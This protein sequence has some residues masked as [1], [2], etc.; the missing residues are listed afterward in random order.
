[1]AATAAAGVPALPTA[2]TRAHTSLRVC[3]VHFSDFRVDSR[4]QRQARA[5]AERGDEVDCVCLSDDADLPMGAGRVRLHNVRA[6][7]RRGGAR[8]YLGSYTRF[9][10]GAARAVTALDRR[11]SFDLVEVHNMPDFLTFAAARPKLRGAPLILNLHDTFPELFASLFGLAD[12]HPL[13]RGVRL[14]E[15]VSA[16]AADALVF[17]TDEAR[18]LVASRGVARRA[19]VVMNS[20]DERLFGPRREPEPLPSSGPVRAV[21]HGGLAERFGVESLVHAFGRLAQSDPD[22]SLDVYGSDAPEAGEVAALAERVAPANV[23]V[24]PQPT[25]VDEI[26]ARLSEA[27]I[28]VVPTLR[29]RF[30]ELLL[31]VKLLEC[32]HMGLPVVSSRLP[33]IESY[34]SEREVRFFEP[35]SPESL[36]EAIGDVRRNPDE[37]LWRARRASARLAGIEWSRQREAYLSLVDELVHA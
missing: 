9:F 16:R 27:H 26:P 19:Q 5:L 31:P 18:E 24:A 6:T 3:M 20:P 4:I 11:H 2:R 35:G 15:R 37:A 10:S 33:V 32:V 1:M 30:T 13:V 8:A 25:P 22:L 7:K 36:A 14:E 28:G 21:Y 23:R 12:G 17:V 34:F 29:D